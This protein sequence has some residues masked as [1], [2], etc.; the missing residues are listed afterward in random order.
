MDSVETSIKP[1][2]TT[3]DKR[4]EDEQKSAFHIFLLQANKYLS[5]EK[6]KMFDISLQ[7]FTKL[8]FEVVLVCLMFDT[9]LLLLWTVVC[10]GIHE[11]CQMWDI[12]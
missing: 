6:T 3:I 1:K 5:D 12:N 4:G 8:L 7:L 9:R 11:I 10:N 2:Q